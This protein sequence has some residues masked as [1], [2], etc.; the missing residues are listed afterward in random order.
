MI[1]ILPLRGEW[2]DRVQESAAEQAN[3]N[4]PTPWGVGPLDCLTMQTIKEFQSSHSVGSGTSFTSRVYIFGD[5][6]I[7]PLRGEWDTFPVSNFCHACYFNPPTP[8]GVGQQK[9]TNFS[10]I[11]QRYEQ[12]WFAPRGK[13]SMADEFSIDTP[14]RLPMIPGANLPEIGCVL[15]LRTGKSRCNGING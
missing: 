3:F 9:Y 4:P 13:I 6:S 15:F 1:S 12:I 8:W 10:L 14:H 11:L 7:L 2:D 5:I